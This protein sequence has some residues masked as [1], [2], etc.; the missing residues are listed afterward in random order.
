MARF[1]AA[2]ARASARAGVL[3]MEDAQVIARVSD[4]A[5]FDA[6]ALAREA[7]NAATPAIPF[8]KALTAASRRIFAFRGEVGAFRCDES[9]RDRHR[10]RFMRAAGG[11][12]LLALVA[13]LGRAVERVLA[14]WEAVRAA[15]S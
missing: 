13:R 9:G 7:R 6:A 2:L 5:H 1:E 12:R 4:V 8:V 14:C 11:A 15:R 10:A 3:P